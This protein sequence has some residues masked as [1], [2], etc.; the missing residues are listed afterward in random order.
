MLTGTGGL[1]CFARHVHRTPKMKME[2][3]NNNNNLYFL[4]T[5]VC[6]TA[7]ILKYIHNRH[8]RETS[9]RNWY[10]NTC[11]TGGLNLFHKYMNLLESHLVIKLLDNSDLS[12]HSTITINVS[13]ISVFHAIH[14]KHNRMALK[15]D[16]NVCWIVSKYNSL[17]NVM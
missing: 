16:Y 2:N 13:M 5:D 12:V 15:R 14:K 3:E 1:R 4:N 8:F 7:W 6:S 10:W 11:A 17:I 9:A